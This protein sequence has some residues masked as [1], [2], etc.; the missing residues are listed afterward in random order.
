MGECERCGRPIPGDQGVCRMCQ[1]ESSTGPAGPARKPDEAFESELR[2]LQSA[3]LADEM[4]RRRAD[5]VLSEN[6]PRWKEGAPACTGPLSCIVL[7]L[8]LAGPFIYFA[9]RLFATLRPLEGGLVLAAGMLI[10]G[11]IWKAK[12][13]FDESIGAH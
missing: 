3:V 10:L 13:R 2:Q 12:A 9:W 1:H 7:S 5:A 11:G 8:L 4:T 6:M